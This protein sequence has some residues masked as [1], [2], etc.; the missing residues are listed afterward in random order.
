MRCPDGATAV[1]STPPPPHCRIP[2]LTLFPF[3]SFLFCS[4]STSSISYTLISKVSA[5]APAPHRFEEACGPSGPSTQHAPGLDEEE[6]EDV[7]CL[8]ER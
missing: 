7:A 2:E 4:R 3:L 1:I 6:D 5:V 8:E